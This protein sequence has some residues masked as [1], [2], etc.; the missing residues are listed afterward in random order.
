MENHPI[1]IRYGTNCIR[2]QYLG[3]IPNCPCKQE[4]YP[5]P[6]TDL[7]LD[8]LGMLHSHTISILI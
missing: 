3:S 6:T 8:I 4:H 1:S 5:S 7:M 2:P